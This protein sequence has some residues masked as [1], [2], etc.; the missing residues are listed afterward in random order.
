MLRA[1]FETF[2]SAEI[3]KRL[4]CLV[5]LVSSC[6]NHTGGSCVSVE[7]GPPEGLSGELTRDA[8]ASC[9]ELGDEL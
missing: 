7:T 4:D 1:A 3:E 9:V 5:L 2:Q 6:T 8:R